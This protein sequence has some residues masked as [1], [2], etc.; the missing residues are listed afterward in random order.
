MNA[1]VFFPHGN[2]MLIALPTSTECPKCHRTVRLCINREGTTLCV[3]CDE[4]VR[5]SG[6]GVRP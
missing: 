4:T 1:P 5:T 6:N 3:A 2:A